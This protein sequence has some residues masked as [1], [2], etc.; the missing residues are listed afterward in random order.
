MPQPQ[1]QLMIFAFITEHLLQISI[2]T[3]NSCKYTHLN[4]KLLLLT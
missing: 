2:Q 1:N 4:T 3:K